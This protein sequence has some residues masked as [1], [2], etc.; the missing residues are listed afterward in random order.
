MEAEGLWRTHRGKHKHVMHVL[1]P[2]PGWNQTLE[3]GHYDK[4]VCEIFVR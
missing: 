3:S 4:V 1:N 2:Q